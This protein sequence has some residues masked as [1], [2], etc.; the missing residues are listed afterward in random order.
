MPHPIQKA[1]I[2]G[3]TLILIKYCRFNQK[4]LKQKYLSYKIYKK[5]WPLDGLTIYIG[6]VVNIINALRL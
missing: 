4:G 2:D 5:N 3:F 6:E 1:N